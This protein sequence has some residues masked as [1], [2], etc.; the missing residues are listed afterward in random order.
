VIAWKM[1]AG[2]G[3][4]TLLVALLS[5][6]VL[7]AG[8]PPRTRSV[9]G[10]GIVE[11]N[12]SEL[13]QDNLV[14]VLSALPLHEQLSRAEFRAGTL[15]VDLKIKSSQAGPAPVYED[16]AELAELALLR[17]S[18]V[19]HLRLRVV[20][21]DPWTDSKHLLLAAELNRLELENE[22]EAVI[23]QLRTTGSEPLEQQL[24]TR[25]HIVETG[26]WRKAFQPGAT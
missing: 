3:S 4:L 14:D 6:L 1:F 17:S 22:R 8:E 20:A 5:A 23:D 10:E 9:A 7:N 13:A 2:V 26:L 11:E 19:Q 21:E 12:F 24:K 25:L 16:M 18:N 15:A